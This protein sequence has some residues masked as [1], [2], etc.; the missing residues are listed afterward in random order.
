MDLRPCRGQIHLNC[1][2][3]SFIPVTLSEHVAPDH[4]RLSILVPV[5]N[6]EENIRKCLDS[7]LN[8]TYTDYECICVDNGST[9]RSL[10]IMKEYEA[11]DPRFKV[12]HKEHGGGLSG[13]RNYCMDRYCGDIVSFIDSDDYVDIHLYELTVPHMDE[14]DFV[15]FNAYNDNL[16]GLVSWDLPVEGLHE[17]TFEISNELRPSVWNKLYRADLLKK[18]N[19]RFPENMQSE[20]CMFSHAYRTLIDKAYFVNDRLYYYVE[21]PNSLTAIIHKRPND[22]NLDQIRV[23]VPFYEFLENNDLVERGAKRHLD[24]WI[25]YTWFEL[26]IVPW[27]LKPRCLKVAWSVARRTHLLESFRLC[28]KNEGL[29]S[30]LKMMLPSRKK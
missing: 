17:L 29:K 15:Q 12:Y 28:V 19:L 5:Y 22:K 9:D 24:M 8:Q 27:K 21:H 14:C 4:P 1:L 11:K 13:C 25:S 7:I 6:Q 30:T 2:T 3:S 16:D 10:E 18:Y 26:K 20:D 23:I